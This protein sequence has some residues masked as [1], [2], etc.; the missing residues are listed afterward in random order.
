MGMGGELD[1]DGGGGAG[2]P[3]GTDFT[4]DTGG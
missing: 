1:E 4:G 3:N 2:L